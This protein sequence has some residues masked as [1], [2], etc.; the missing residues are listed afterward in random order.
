MNMLWHWTTFTYV[1][2]LKS[3]Q[4]YICVLTDNI[5]LPK[6]VECWLNVIVGFPEEKQWFVMMWIDTGLS[7]TTYAS[8]HFLIT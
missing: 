8:A 6:K 3:K 1:H 5:V 2:V 7:A 4:L